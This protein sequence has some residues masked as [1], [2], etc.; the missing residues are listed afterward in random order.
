M[1]SSRVI[2]NPD[3]L[4]SVSEKVQYPVADPVTQAEVSRFPVI[5]MMEIVLSNEMKFRDELKLLP[6]VFVK[7][8]LRQCR[9]HPV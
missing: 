1:L 4:G 8:E 9:W 6:S 5:F 3:C 7:T 2:T